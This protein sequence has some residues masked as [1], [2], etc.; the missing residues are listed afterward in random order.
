MKVIEQQKERANAYDEENDM[1]DAF[2][3]CGGNQ[4]KTGHVERSTLVRNVIF[5]ANCVH[6]MNNLRFY[7]CRCESLKKILDLLSIL[8]N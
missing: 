8:R 6:D 7:L 1:I 4:D 2:V 5:S 3:A